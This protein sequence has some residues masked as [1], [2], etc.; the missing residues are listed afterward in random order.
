MSVRRTADTALNA[1]QRL[2]LFHGTRLSAEKALVVTEEE[3]NFD[4]MMTHGVRAVSIATAG[5]KPLVLKTLGV[6]NSA[7][8][9]R[10]G[11]DALH[12]V[13]EAWCQEAAAAYGASDVIEAFVQTPSD[14][15]ALAG[16]SA[17]SVL[18][19]GVQKLLEVCAGAPT[20]ALSVLQQAATES[21]LDG[22]SAA[23]LLDTGLRAPQLQQMGLG[24]AS[25]RSLRGL[26]AH[27]LT[28]FG[29]KLP[30]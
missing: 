3:I 8:L 14:A 28:K 12:L 24:L 23:T 15:V 29:F 16:T 5:V 11:F 21:P 2:T 18:G 17:L 27:D 4:F 7:Q 30:M 25:V 13:D 10:L 1:R 9:R 26:G 6:A 22:V 19:I 20:E